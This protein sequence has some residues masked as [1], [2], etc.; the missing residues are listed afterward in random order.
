MQ[1]RA[2]I[3]LLI[4]LNLA[5]VAV[6][7]CYGS[8]HI[9]LEELLEERWH[10]IVWESRMPA[11]ITALLTGS[12]LASCGLLLQSYF[13]NPLA[14]PSILGITNGA[15][16]MVA[17]VTLGG[18][19][20]SITWGSSFEMKSVVV[21]AAFIGSFLVLALLLFLGRI[22]RSQVTLLIIGILLSYLSSALITLLGY[23]ASAQGF[24]QLMLWGMGDFSSVSITE[25]PGFVLLIVIG[26]LASLLLIK[27]LNG[28]MQG[29]K[30]AMNLGIDL[31]KTRLMVLGVTGLLTAVTTA[32]CGPIAFVGLSMP[33]V[34]R[35]LLKTDDHGKLMPITILL[36]GLCCSLCLWLSTRPDGGTLLPIN[37]L[38][39]LFGVPVIVYVLLKK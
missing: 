14:G 5:A 32:W 11:A 35:M 17:L 20:W 28:W 30:Y 7:I 29:E 33:H 27:P 3:F 39:P 9:P 1:T 15:N 36:G 12:A 38:T 6:N 19:R 31:R 16:L 8:I 2:V 4:L 23:Y 13:R 24:Q 37:A 22:V 21:I 18:L 34:A 10:F 26:L 25:L